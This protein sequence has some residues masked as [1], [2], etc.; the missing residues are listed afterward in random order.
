VSSRRLFLPRGNA[1]EKT[2]S[3]SPKRGKQNQP[4]EI[5]QSKNKTE[6]TPMKPHYHYQSKDRIV[7]VIASTNDARHPRHPQPMALVKMRPQA[8]TRC[9]EQGGG[10]TL[11]LTFEELRAIAEAF[12]ACDPS[13]EIKMSKRAKNKPEWRKRWWQEQNRKRIAARRTLVHG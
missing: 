13:F 11:M 12:K 10:V 6:K 4:L 8:H 9:R 1:A 2:E 3:Q 5:E 7:E